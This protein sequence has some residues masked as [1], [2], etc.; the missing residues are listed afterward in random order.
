MTMTRRHFVSSC[1]VSTAAVAA[2]RSQARAGRPA[3]QD[4]TLHV[5]CNSYPWTT[6]ARRDKQPFDPLSDA[7]IAAVSKSGIDGYEPG[8]KGPE[9]IDRLSPLLKKHGIEMRSIYMN[10]VLHDARE[11]D[12]SIALIRRVAERAR[13]VGTRIVVTNPSPLQWGGEAVKDDRQLAT[14]AEALN[15]LGKVLNASGLKLVYHNHNMELRAAAR[16]FHHMLLGTDPE[17]VSFCLDA[18]WVYRGSQQSQIALFDVVKL[19]GTRVVELHIRQSSDHVWT[20]S[21]GPGDIDYQ[22]LVG[23]FQRL[24]VAP[25]LVLEQAVEKG[26]PHALDA[27]DA[28][29]AS[30]AVVRQWFAPLAEI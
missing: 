24:G 6:F 14:Q 13:A 4:K 28:H 17:N 16:E 19:Y 23:E 30:A 8:I 27:I 22:R 7:A 12:A 26:S 1:V 10:S 2:L 15:R 5:A 29:R 20:E 25:H 21:F 18:H 9:D 11:A 3:G